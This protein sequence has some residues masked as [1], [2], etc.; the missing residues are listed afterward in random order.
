MPGFGVPMP[1]LGGYHTA[2]TS[3]YHSYRKGGHHQHQKKKK[4]KQ[5]LELMDDSGGMYHLI[6]NRFRSDWRHTDRKIKRIGHIY[7]INLDQA[8][9]DAQKQYLDSITK[10][11]G[12]VNINSNLWH[13]TS[14]NCT[15]GDDP[16]NLNLCRHPDCCLCQILRGGYKHSKAQSSGMF[17]KGI[18]STQISSKAAGFSTNNGRSEYKAI[19]LNTV[20]LGNTYETTKP[21]RY[22]T[23]PPS[24]YD[25]VYGETGDSSSLKFPE[26]CVYNDNAIQPTNLVLFKQVSN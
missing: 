16:K 25:S 22:A 15:V 14:R 13:G 1:V 12:R 17:G 3:S 9:L 11:R 8:T 23:K 19:L 5:L 24:G 21:L 20:V 4:T 26:Y 2:S 18:Y 7:S 10:S 6:V